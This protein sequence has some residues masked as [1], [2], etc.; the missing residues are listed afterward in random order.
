MYRI[1]LRNFKLY[2]RI[3]EYYC[4]AGRFSKTIKPLWRSIHRI[5]LRNFEDYCRAFP[6]T[7][8][9]TS[10]YLADIEAMPCLVSIL[11]HPNLS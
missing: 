9:H 1:P 7:L 6:K 8:K 10:A 4:R 11:L 5:P 3:F 2:R